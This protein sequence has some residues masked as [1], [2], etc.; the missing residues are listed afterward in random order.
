MS[1]GW[2]KF[3]VHHKPERVT[4]SEWALKWKLDEPITC[5]NLSEDEVVEE[6]LE[7]VEIHLADLDK[8]EGRTVHDLADEHGVLIERVIDEKYDDKYR[9][10]R[11]LCA[12]HR[13]RSMLE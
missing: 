11:Y 5:E 7:Q 13:K 6:S 2:R 12:I 8:A 4:P 10:T 9:V 1:G 3:A